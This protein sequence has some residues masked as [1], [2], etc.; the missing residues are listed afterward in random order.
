MT[1]SERVFLALQSRGSATA[2]QIAEDVGISI[3][4][5]SSAITYLKSSGLVFHVGETPISRHREVNLYST[6]AT[7]VPA[8]PVTDFKRQAWLSPIGGDEI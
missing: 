1:D 3:K 7:V 2:S 6:V 8:A 4:K 5:T